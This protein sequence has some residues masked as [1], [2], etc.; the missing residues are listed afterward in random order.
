MASHW[1][2]G[3]HLMEPCDRDELT[4]KRS[5]RRR[6]TRCWKD[7]W[8]QDMSLSYAF[9]RAPVGVCSVDLIRF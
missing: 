9:V 1:S 6:R 5:V 4:P 7:R 2:S 8:V 3:R